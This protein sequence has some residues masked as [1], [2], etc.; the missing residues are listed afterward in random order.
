VRADACLRTTS[1]DVPGLPRVRRLRFGACLHAGDSHATG[2]RHCRAHPEHGI[3]GRYIVGFDPHTKIF[4]A[5]PSG[6]GNA[7]VRKLLG[8][9]GEVRGTESGIDRLVVIETE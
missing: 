7:N 5:F 4:T 2:L 1:A 9:R 8:R 6:R 3:Y